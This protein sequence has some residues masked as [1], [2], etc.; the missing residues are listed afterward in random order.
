MET[1]TLHS[2]TNFFTL[3]GRLLWLY[4]PDTIHLTHFVTFSLEFMS[5][6]GASFSF[7]SLHTHKIRCILI[8]SERHRGRERRS[9][10][11]DDNSL[12]S[13]HFRVQIPNELLSGEMLHGVR[14]CV[15]G[16][17]VSPIGKYRKDYWIS[18]VP[19]V[20][21]DRRI[22][23]SFNLTILQLLKFQVCQKKLGVLLKTE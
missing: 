1:I 5:I 9:H 12:W 3:V 16:N 10:T 4:A 18:W 15:L 2:N 11:L 20:K 8:N 14:V 13:F 7:S 19:F 22:L 23:F 21:R 17:V 6:L